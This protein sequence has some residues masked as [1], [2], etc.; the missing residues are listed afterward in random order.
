MIRL[1]RDGTI[2]TCAFGTEKLRARA[3]LPGAFAFDAAAHAVARA[4]AAGIPAR[5]LLPL[6]LGSSWLVN[7]AVPSPIFRRWLTPPLEGAWTE[8]LGALAGGPW[9]WDE[10][11]KAERDAIARAVASLAVDGH[12]AGAVSKVLALLVPEVPL[13]PDAALW[14]ATGSVPRPDKPD[15]QTAGAEAF[16]PMMDWFSRET[17]SNEP[18]LETLAETYGGPPLT[19]AQTLDRLVWFESVGYRHFRSKTGAGFFWVK[20]GE[21][22]AVIMLDVPREGAALG[23]PV[24]LTAPECPPAVRDAARRA[25]D[26]ASA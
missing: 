4:R 24:D 5:E 1:S 10:R 26:L 2:W 23:D 17:A 18:D 13:M 11:T 9:S 15:A 22:E 12:G 20:D 7:S 19:A 25:L 3:R 14:F 8:L 6:A 16:V 21:R